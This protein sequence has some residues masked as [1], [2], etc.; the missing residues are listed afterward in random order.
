[1]DSK[2]L[3]PTCNNE[4][5]FCNLLHLIFLCFRTNSTHH[6]ISHLYNSAWYW[7]ILK[8]VDQELVVIFIQC[9]NFLACG[10]KSNGI[11]SLSLNC[12]QRMKN[13]CW[14]F[15]TGTRDGWHPYMGHTVMI[16]QAHDY[17]NHPFIYKECK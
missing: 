16:I 15:S 6:I 3:S 13:R 7:D 5:I 8:A 2:Y 14:P 17:K 9:N 10:N 4:K 12:F 1:M 11:C